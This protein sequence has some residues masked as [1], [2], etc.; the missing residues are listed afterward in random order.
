MQAADTGIPA[1]RE[2]QPINRPHADELVIDQ[3]GRHPIQRQMP[4]LLA[5]DFMR[6]GKRYQVSEAFHGHAVAVAYTLLDRRAQRQYACT[7]THTRS[8]NMAMPW[9]TPMHM[10]AMPWRPWPRSSWLI[11]VVTKRAP[12]APS[13]WPIAIAPPLGL[14]RSSS[15]A[16]PSSRITANTCA[17]NASLSSMASICGSAMADFSSNLRIAGTGPIP[18]MRGATPAV[19]VAM[20]RARGVRPKRCAAACVA[21]SS[22]HEPSLTGEALP[23]VTVPPLLTIGFRFPRPSSVLSARGASSTSTCSVAPR[24]RATLQVE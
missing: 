22:A 6:G 5:D 12:L 11:S 20:I 1:P 16:S 2:H 18:M 4:A 15:S 19:V 9:P 21:S 3:I 8:I 23:A 17:A 7:H 14:T 10:L 24:P 13:G